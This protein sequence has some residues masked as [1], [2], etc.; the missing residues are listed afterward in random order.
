MNSRYD[1]KNTL[2]QLPTCPRC[3]TAITHNLRYSNYIKPQLA[4]IEKIKLKYYG[5]L[6]A[7]NGD[8]FQLK[9]EINDLKNVLFYVF[10]LVL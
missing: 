7:N 4:L 9:N 10:S 5:D 3:K 2:I 8:V 1:T 6:K